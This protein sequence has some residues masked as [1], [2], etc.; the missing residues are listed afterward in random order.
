MENCPALPWWNLISTCN[1]RVKYA[2]AGRVEISSPKTFVNFFLTYWRHILRKNTIEISS[3]YWNVFYGYFLFLIKFFVAL[4][5]TETI[6]WENFV[7]VKRDPGST[8]AGSRLARMKLFPCNHRIKFMKSLLYCRD[9]GK[10]GQNFIPA[11]RDH[12]ITPI[13]WNLFS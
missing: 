1:C 5:R 8:K 12:V 13:Q 9:P 7:P 4:R 11:K 2:P 6:T 10:A 3:I